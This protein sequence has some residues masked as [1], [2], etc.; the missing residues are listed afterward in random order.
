MHVPGEKWGS[1]GVGVW[2]L[3]YYFSSV[4]LGHAKKKKKV[5]KWLWQTCTI[6]N[7][8]DVYTLYADI[9]ILFSK[10]SKF[11]KIISLKKIISHTVKCQVT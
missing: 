4:S 5:T 2:I 3:P 9:V 8:W 11:F 1:L 6:I 7:S 10:K